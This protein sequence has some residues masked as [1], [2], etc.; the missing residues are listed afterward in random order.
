MPKD[1]SFTLIS[2]LH[3]L[4][5]VTITVPV[6][7][8]STDKA[9]KHVRVVVSLQHTSDTLGFL[10][11]N[12][13]KIQGKY[14]LLAGPSGIGKSTY[15]EYLSKA[16]GATVLA[17]DWVAIEREGNCFYASDLNFTDSIR[18][19]GK[20][21]LDGVVF[22]ASGDTYG[23]DVFVPNDQEYKDLLRE[24]FDTTSDSELETLSSFWL[25][26]RDKLPLYCAIPARRKPEA[27]IAQT[28]LGIIHKAADHTKEIEVGIIGVGAIGAELAF[29]LGQLSIVSKVHLF[30][31]TPE[32]AR[33]Y[34]LD[35]NHAV[36]PGKSGAIFVAH[37]R[38]EEVFM[39]A[40][41]VFLTFRDESI[42][43]R[44]ELPERW[45][46]LPSHLEIMKYYA[47]LASDTK[48]NGTI[49]V[50]TNPVDILTYVC[51]A[52]TQR[53]K[54]PLRTHQVFG[55]GLEVDV[56]RT[57]SY[58]HGLTKDTVDVYGNH[59]D[60]FVLNTP[61]SSKSNT[62]L[63]RAI[64]DASAEVRQYIPR[65]VYGPVAAAIR[66]FQ[67]YAQDQSTYATLVQEDAHM[68]RKVYFRHGLPMLD[69]VPATQ[70]YTD[71]LNKNRQAIA[72]Y[73]DLL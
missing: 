28:I 33:G 70:A 9:K 14:F 25:Q 64:Q 26:S 50:V 47:K 6:K 63:H 30:N 60:D 46:K 40:S 22:L 4:P 73:I 57:L 58:E 17:N 36:P 15:A 27:Y 29:Q 52:Y 23:R 62:D 1:T 32:K 13:L 42:P 7:G 48:F 3:S 67:A 55:I 66:T 53:G 43:P 8:L 72:S 21:L 5:Q 49:F 69:E 2:R 31:R 44:P 35:M 18:H 37:K 45:R 24:T 56:A 20:C 41:V 12:L 59:T 38:A 65:T 39:Y 54:L 10:H 68:G 51:H 34:A 19:S 71:I 11:A 16:T 61:L